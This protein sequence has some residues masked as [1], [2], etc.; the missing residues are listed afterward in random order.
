M[1]KII[2]KY[3]TPNKYSR[4]Q[5]PMKNIKGIVIHWVANPNTS[6]LANRNYF[7][8]RKYGL[9]KI[10]Y[11]SAH[12]IIDLNGDIITCIPK[13][14]IAY[15]AGSKTYLPIAIQKLGTYPNSCTYH[16]ECTHI[17]WDGTMTDVTYKS[18]VNRC[19]NLCFEYNLNPLVDLWLHE[20][21]TGKLCHR[22]FVDNP[23]KWDFFKKKV[24][25]IMKYTMLKIN[26][27]GKDIKLDEVVNINDKNYVGIREM[28]EK[29]GFKVDWD[30][31][32]V[33]IGWK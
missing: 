27:F 18:L 8:N 25:N 7:E 12:E 23:D 5:I 28:F 3:L 6:A 33:N 11:G 22:W 16:I 30:G 17:D 14:E 4:P 2:E 26:F 13:N 1:Y 31:E 10:L 9:T 21:I 19:A 24:N 15:G 32:K 20:E 29:I